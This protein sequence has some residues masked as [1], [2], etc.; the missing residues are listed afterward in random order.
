[1]W[2][3]SILVFSTEDTEDAPYVLR[4]TGRY[5]HSSRYIESL[6]EE[7]GCDSIQSTRRLA[8]GKRCVDHGES[9]RSELVLP[10]SRVRVVPGMP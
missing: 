2:G 10:E 6:A 3:G 7:R 4:A 1:M 5:A 9:L 8:K